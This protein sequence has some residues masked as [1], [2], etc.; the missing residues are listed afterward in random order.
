M[1]RNLLVLLLLLLP[2]QPAAASYAAAPPGFLRVQGRHIVDSTGR[3]VS[4]RG[5]NM[6]TFYYALPWN[7]NAAWEYADQQD[8]AYLAD[9]GVTSI[10]LAVHWR[11]FET[12]LG[13]DLI[14]AYLDWC[15]QAG[16]Y[17][18]LDM[19]VVPPAED[20]VNP[21]IWTDPAVQQQMLD[22]WAEIAA[23]YA[24]RTILA[25]YDLF[26]EPG[27][28]DAAQWWSLAQRL[29]AAI[30]AVDANHMLFV[31]L[32]TTTGAAFQRIGDANVV[33]SYHDYTPFVVSHAGAEW[34]GDSPIPDNYSYP[35]SVLNGTT[36]ANYA[37]DAP[38]YSQPFSDWTQVDSGDL[39]VPAAVEF[40]TL[41]PATSG[42]A[43]DVWF[44]DFALWRNG[45]VQPLVNA[46]AE[47]ASGADPAWPANW[48]FWSSSDGRG[49]AWSTIAAHS[50]TRSLQLR[51][52]DDGFAIWGQS[53][54]IFTAPLVAVQPGDTLRVQ[55]WLLA[56]DNRGAV[57]LGVDYLNGVY[58]D[59][60]ATRLLA[61]VQPYLDWAAAE[62]VPLYVG[63]FGAM[64][65]APGD[66]RPNLVRDKIALMNR[67]DVHWALW[68]Y[69]DLGDMS[70]G[71]VHDEAL[72][73]TL[74]EVLRQGMRWQR[75][76]L[77]LILARR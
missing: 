5:V 47:T 75:I 60:D 10:R 22:L 50:G 70:F 67:A 3:R 39:Q 11:Y 33:Y 63:E 30:R 56:P 26:N 76:Y 58:E 45:V 4:L 6:D 24:D 69:R 66:S 14:D 53:A 74:A 43:H 18:V 65:R 57:S 27:P 62:G 55:G 52:S 71:L 40:A 61:D 35:G 1:L 9:L 28:P 77:P 25:G 59:Y 2:V 23:R 21:A 46:D 7:P 64:G 29:T 72:D 54:W 68:T 32:P 36:W 15:E 34:V 19:H 13:Y 12:T 37:A 51:G 38:S 42:A 49:G 48:Y 44:D 17:V 73:E 16:I 20:L 8:I 31:E 41:K